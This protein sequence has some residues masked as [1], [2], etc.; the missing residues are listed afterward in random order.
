MKA[1]QNV[2]HVKNKPNFI[3]KYWH[4]VILEINTNSDM[5]QNTSATNIIKTGTI[6][7]KIENME[8]LQFYRKLRYINR[9]YY[10]T[11]P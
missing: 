9:N 2:K 1:E 11:G 8:L 5:E 4:W 6:L 3:A 10:V 7:S